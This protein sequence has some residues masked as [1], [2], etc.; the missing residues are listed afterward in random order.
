[1]GKPKLTHYKR[2]MLFMQVGDGS[3]SY[4]YGF[5]LRILYPNGRI[6][7]LSYN[8]DSDWK[9]DQHE[10]RATCYDGEE[11]QDSYYHSKFNKY[12][13]CKYGSKYTRFRSVEDALYVMRM[14][15]KECGYGNAE[16]LGYL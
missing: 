3:G 15:D 5:R 2:P 14:H 8:E 6:C 11:L 16:F 10:F 4:E 7:W 13:V 9:T 1:M 12:S